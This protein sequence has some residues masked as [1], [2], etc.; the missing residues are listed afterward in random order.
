MGFT[1]VCAGLAVADFDAALAWYERLLGRPP[2]ARPMDGLAE[3]R[4]AGT[5]P[6]QVV[7]D[8]GRA[9]GS[10][11]TLELDDVREH[12]AGLEGRGFRDVAIDDTSS[13]TVLFT[14]LADP[15][16]NAITLVEPRAA[17]EATSALL[18]LR[19][20]IYPAPDLERSKT[21]FSGLLDFAPYFDEPFYVGFDVGGY[22]LA[23]HP[24]YDPADGVRTYWGVADADA[25]LAA[26][27]AAGA[28]EHEAVQDVGGGIRV[29]SV[30]EP[31]GAI[32]GVIENPHF[33]ARNAASP[34]PGR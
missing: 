14:T 6:I 32:L 4:F 26:L 15:D 17:A 5:G 33:A 2:D 24:G 10:L 12:V 9:G 22:E 21:W 29:A 18:G 11:I 23:L 16:G 19:T 25:A 34:G 1:T 20:A 3:W 31:G 7:E 30:R 8:A 13:D 28:D 27:H